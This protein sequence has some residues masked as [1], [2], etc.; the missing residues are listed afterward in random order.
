MIPSFCFSLCFFLS[1]AKMNVS[2]ATLWITLCLFCLLDV[3]WWW[4]QACEGCICS[5][6]REG[7]SHYIYWWTGCYRYKGEPTSHFIMFNF[8]CLQCQNTVIP[9]IKLKTV[10]S[11]LQQIDPS[12]KNSF[13]RLVL[14]IIL[15]KRFKCVIWRS[16]NLLHTLLYSNKCFTG[17]YTFYTINMKLHPGS[18]EIRV[19]WR[20]LLC[21]DI[22]RLLYYSYQLPGISNQ[23]S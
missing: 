11:T 22:L 1:A 16:F 2:V 19:M 23:W 15:L 20:S 13:K 9:C 6:Q 4:S 17:K 5:S 12:T 3:Y 7:P 21:L 14:A 10:V 8:W 18:I